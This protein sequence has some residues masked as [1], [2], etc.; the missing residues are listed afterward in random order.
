MMLPK[1]RGVSA[2]DHTDWINAFVAA[3]ERE[4]AGNATFGAAV[5]QVEGGSGGGGSV[6]LRTGD[7]FMSFRTDAAP[8]GAIE[9]L[10]QILLR[11]EFPALFAAI[12]TRF[13]IGGEG[14]TEFRVPNFQGRAPVGANGT[15]PIYGGAAS[16]TIAKANLPAYNLTVTDPGHAHTFT[17][18][19]HT[20]TLADPGHTHT[21]SGGTP[22]I[23]GTPVNLGAGSVSVPTSQGASLVLSASATGITANNA[24]AGGN[25]AS[26]NTG[27]SVALGGSGT[28]L[29]VLQPYVTGRWFIIT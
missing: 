21:V 28:G 13:N 1:L 8:N 2:K 4:N 17:G 27:I 23:V 26:H 11:S 6:V 12:N 19:A 5:S 3:A 7:C 22:A 29:S 10:G 18:T 24:T 14:D 25:I 20:H 16:V 15:L 9:C